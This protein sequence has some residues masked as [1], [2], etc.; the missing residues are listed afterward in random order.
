MKRD[1]KLRKIVVGL[2]EDLIITGFE[3]NLMVKIKPAKN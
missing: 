3:E 1:F 2:D